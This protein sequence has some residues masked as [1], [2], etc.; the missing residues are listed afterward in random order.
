MFKNTINNL[1][2][3]V[4][5]G[6]YVYLHRKA[7]NGE[8]FYVGKGSDKRCFDKS[9]RSDYWKRVFKKHGVVVEIYESGLQEWYANELEINLI[10]YYG[11]KNLKLGSLINLTDGGEGIVG[12]VR[13][14]EC[15]DLHF[16][17]SR[18]PRADK[19][20]YRFFNVE[21][22]EEFNGTRCDFTE[23]TG[24]ISQDLFQGQVFADAW[25][26]YEN[27]YK[28]PKFSTEVYR[29]VNC[30]TGEIFVGN[31]RQFKL[32]TGVNS[33]PLFSNTNTRKFVDGWYVLTH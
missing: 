3:I 8:V 24:I 28:I 9:H 1:D 14:K 5:G 4:S 6:C 16:R 19:K 17:G 7:T 31:R 12:F 21:T 13:S 30:Y 26:L 33:K 10:A 2:K 20:I 18:N 11:R 29:F 32:K 23:Y 22:Q 25:C 27:R 15:L